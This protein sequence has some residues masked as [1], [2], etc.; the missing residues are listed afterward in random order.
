MEIAR[1]PLPLLR[2]DLGSE[3]VEELDVLDHQRCLTDHLLE[4]PQIGL[5]VAETPRGRVQPSDRP[6]PEVDGHRDERVSLQQIRKLLQRGA[7]G[8]SQLEAHAIVGTDDGAL[9]EAAAAAVHHRE[10]RR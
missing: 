5:H 6:M 9:P 8:R 3:P 10:L 1:D 2:G 7:L 4:E